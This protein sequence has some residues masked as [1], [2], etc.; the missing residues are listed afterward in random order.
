[1]KV[2]M[3]NTDKLIGMIGGELRIENTVRWKRTV[4]T[5][6]CHIGRGG[7]SIVFT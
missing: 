2:F 1:M 4:P 5:Y 3:V 6:T 7:N